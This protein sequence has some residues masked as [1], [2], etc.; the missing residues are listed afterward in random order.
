MLD[1]D[2]RVLRR[3]V[4]ATRGPHLLV[5]ELREKALLERLERRALVL[6]ESGVILESTR[7]R[8]D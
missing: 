6:D 7:L 3:H 8:M 5:P 4:V 2:D 1:A